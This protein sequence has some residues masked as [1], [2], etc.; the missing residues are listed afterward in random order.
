MGGKN[1][2]PFTT[3]TGLIDLKS[4]EARPEFGALGA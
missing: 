3:Q 4:T 2:Y 1:A